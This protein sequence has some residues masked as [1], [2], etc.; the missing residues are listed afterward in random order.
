M[1]GPIF[2]ICLRFICVIIYEC[3]WI[4]IHSGR[5][6]WRGGMTHVFGDQTRSNF[7]MGQHSRVSIVAEK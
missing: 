2:S 7:K 4:R 5:E 6:I 1:M 3:H